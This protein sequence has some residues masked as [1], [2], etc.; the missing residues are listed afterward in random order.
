MNKQKIL[1]QLVNKKTK[2]YSFIIIFFIIFS[3]FTFFVIKPNLTTVFSLQRDLV[4]LRRLDT[5]YEQ[6]INNIISVQSSFE[7]NRDKFSL[8]DQALPGAPKVNQVVDDINKIASDAGLLMKRMT[9]SEVD[10]KISKNKEKEKQ[11]T[12]NIDIDSGFS[13]ITKFIEGITDQRRL[14][15][16]KEMTLSKNLK[17]GTQSSTLRIKIDLDGYYL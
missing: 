2:D 3:F 12:V 4:D 11:Y 13:S 17:E 8:L 6:V 10:L 5:Q 16:F 9:I 15:S 1:E 14:K 7:K